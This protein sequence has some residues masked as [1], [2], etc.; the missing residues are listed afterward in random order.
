MAADSSLVQG[1]YRASRDYSGLTRQAQKD[2]DKT[3]SELDK[4]DPQRETSTGARRTKKSKDTPS[5]ED[6]QNVVTPEEAAKVAEKQNK[7][8]TKENEADKVVNGEGVSVNSNDVED[9]VAPDLQADADAVNEALLGGDKVQAALTEANVD[10]KADDIESWN[11]VFGAMGE[12]YGNRGNNTSHGFGMAMENDPEAKSWIEDMILSEQRLE[13]GPE[14]KRYGVYGPDDTFYTPDEFNSLLDNYRVDN[15]SFNAIDTLRDGYI[16]Q[17]AEG[18]GT[19]DRDL[20]MRNVED[21]VNG[22]NIQ[23][24]MFDSHFGGRSFVEDL[25]AGDELN[26][27]TYSSLG[28]EPPKDDEDG[29]IDTGDNIND[30]LKRAI[31]TNF[32]TSPDYKDQSKKALVGY[33]TDHLERNY[34][35]EWAKN[36]PD[37]T[38][39]VNQALFDK[40][41][42]TGTDRTNKSQL[43]PNKTNMTYSGKQ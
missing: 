30:E 32:A 23:S 28:L 4:I 24:L 16:K 34:I 35:N 27:I 8:P 7:P 37:A 39:V 3:L 19:F 1:A 9:V 15:E 18:T 2:F 6:K 29:I 20:A 17:G 10:Q 41:F 14:G 5:T 36:Q 21:I 11:S 12:D 25:I 31:A 13:V 42:G 22:G 40:V 43:I 26:N 33:Y 38:P